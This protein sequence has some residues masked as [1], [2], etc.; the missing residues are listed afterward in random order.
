MG[1]FDFLS[2]ELERRAPRTSAANPIRERDG[3]YNGNLFLKE[4][5]VEPEKGYY[6]LTCVWCGKED[7]WSFKSTS[8]GMWVHYPPDRDAE[9]YPLPDYICDDC[10]SP[11]KNIGNIHIRNRAE[12]H[13]YLESDHWKDLRRAVLR[14]AK[15]KCQ[16]CGS[17]YRLD[18]HHNSYANLGHE[19]PDDLIV[20]CRRC[21]SLHHGKEK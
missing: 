7:S 11:V 15:N 18:V 12:Y 5:L 4:P 21:H 17:K 10:Y 6:F 9:L 19:H 2:G 20:L 13:E 8:P 3:L 16:M 1:L 14:R